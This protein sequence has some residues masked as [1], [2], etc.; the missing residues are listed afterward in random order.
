MRRR[1][2]HGKTSRIQERVSG[3]KHMLKALGCISAVGVRGIHTFTAP[4]S[5][6]QFHRLNERK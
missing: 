6:N 1:Y 2:T 4:Y 3:K 5:E